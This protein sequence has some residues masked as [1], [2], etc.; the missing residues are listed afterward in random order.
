VSLRTS[1]FLAAALAAACGE[2]RVSTPEGDAGAGAGGPDASPADLPLGLHGAYFR[3]HGALAAE[4]V[5]PAV[6]F[7]WGEEEPAAEVGAD[8]FSVR[9]SGY[10]EVPA[11]GTY[12]FA[13]VADDGVRLWVDH[14]AVLDDWSF[15]A[16]TR[17]EGSAELGAGFVPIRLDYFDAGSL[18][19]VSLSWLPPGA[20]AEEV[21][22]EARL[23]ALADA[24]ESPRPPY[25]N[26]VVPFDCPDPGVV[27]VK[28]E[29]G[30]AMVCTGG[31]FPVRRSADLVF[32]DDTASA[33]LPDGK[34][35]WAANGG[36]NWAPEIHALGGRYVA[37]F[38]SVNGA[39][40]L[41]IG[42]ASAADPFGAWTDRGGPLV[43][44]SLGVID[45]SHF[46][47]GDGKHY[48]LYK[49]DGNSQG[50]PTPIYL[51][52]LAGD[53]LSFAAGSQPV[54]LIRND[55][56]SW[57]GGV[58]E[59]PWLIERRGT[60]YL[61]YSG[62]VYDHRYR[63]G[64]ARSASLTGPYEKHGA[65]ILGNNER[66]VGPGHGSVVAIGGADY[67]VYHAWSAAPGGVNDGA[68]GRQVLVDRIAWN[69]DGWPSIFDG[70]P[71][72]S[73]QVWPGASE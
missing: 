31:R 71:S 22:P 3:R 46:K 62:N 25:I 66:W 51:R 65:P 57:E 67:F 60:Y 15:H 63:T 61:F 56:G 20:A 12:T 58:V 30:F 72:R 4:R 5:D 35:A 39:N 9:W 24:G 33:I 49:I 19:E 28:G 23:R 42:A 53:G 14:Q 43:E 8:H 34:P 55:P 36:R 37:Y 41:S 40:V 1:I 59:A 44:A 50:Q 38:T 16:A 48:L 10:L 47:D 18:A 27:E 52:E 21:I 45:A 70:T 13:T 68:R 11:D 64:V 2:G 32:W 69:A 29:G 7:A 73:L 26:P 6:Q 17:V 54:E